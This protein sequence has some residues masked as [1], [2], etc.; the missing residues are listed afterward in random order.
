MGP[1]VLSKEGGACEETS[2]VWLAL[3]ARLAVAWGESAEP[4]ESHSLTDGL[5]PWLVYSVFHVD[6]LTAILLSHGR[7]NHEPQLRS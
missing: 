2:A 4:T 6:L 1:T 5:V 3:P 7:L